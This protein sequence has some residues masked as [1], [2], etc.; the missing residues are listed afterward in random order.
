M[1]SVGAD[2]KAALLWIVLL[3]SAMSG[4]SRTFVREEEI[5]SADI[6]RL[7]GTPT[8]V[9][10][11]KLVFNLGLMALVELVVAPLYFVVLPVPMS[12]GRLLALSGVLVLGGIGMASASTFVAALISLSSGGEG[13]SALFFV[14]AFPVLAPSMLAAVQA[15]FAAIAPEAAPMNAL[16]NGLVMLASYDIVVTTAAFALFGTVWSDA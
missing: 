13:R 8:A 14:V 4:L 1:K 3:F 15:T 9:F 6:L 2:V 12:A 7:L 5:G 11:G 10:A 16:H